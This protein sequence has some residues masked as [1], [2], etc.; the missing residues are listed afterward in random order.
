MDK[1][2]YYEEIMRLTHYHDCQEDIYFYPTKTGDGYIACVNCNDLFYWACGDAESIQIDDVPL[3]KQSLEDS[4]FMGPLL[5]C[6][7]KRKMRP[8]GAYY[9][10]FFPEDVPLFNATGPKREVGFGN[11]KDNIGD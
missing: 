1:L 11:P 3:F 2:E 10:S 8:Q 7:R 6:A 9:E 5:Y 4:E